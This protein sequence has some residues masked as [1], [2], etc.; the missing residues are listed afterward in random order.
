M[1]QSIAI[2]IAS[3][4]G[5]SGVLAAEAV[6]VSADKHDCLFTKDD[7]KPYGFKLDTSGASEST[8][9]K[10]Y[11]DGSKMLKYTYDTR[12]KED[13]TEM[14]FV[15]FVDYERNSERSKATFRSNID[16]LIA[17]GK[18]N[19][20]ECKSEK[21]VIRLGDETEYYLRTRNG[22]LNGFVF[23]ARN[24]GVCYTI[25]TSGLINTDGSMFR[26][27]IQKRFMKL[28]PQKP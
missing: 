14:F 10:T 12:G 6:E 13:F 26:D 20:F 21:P 25:M 23:S 27:E 17:A 24:D 11:D 5:I 4:I 16:T 7:L 3:F 8:T 22:S 1:M 28:I 19:G 18:K 9:L 2:I 15:V